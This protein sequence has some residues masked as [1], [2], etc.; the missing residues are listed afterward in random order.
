VPLSLRSEAMR[1][2]YRMNITF[3]TLFPDL[4]GL[5]RASAFELEIVW[6]GLTGHP[7]SRS[8]EIY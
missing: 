8:E 3:A 6:P 1:T 2:L 5:A 7:Q 4:E